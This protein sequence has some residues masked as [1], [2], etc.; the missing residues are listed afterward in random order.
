MTVDELLTWLRS[1][2]DWWSIG[3]AWGE[4]GATDEWQVQ[5]CDVSGDGYNEPALDVDMVA[6][7]GASVIEAL[8]DA[9]RQ[10]LA[11]A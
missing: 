5:G 7:S 3:N 6:G 8:R 4:S 10:V 1:H 11:D 2:R 9:A